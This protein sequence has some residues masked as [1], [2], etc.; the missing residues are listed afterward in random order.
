M[1]KTYNNNASEESGSLQYSSPEEAWH[2]GLPSTPM[3]EFLYARSGTD[4]FSM[5]GVTF[6]IDAKTQ[7]P[8]KPEIQVISNIFRG[9]YPI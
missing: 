4:L 9:S 1:H 6:P 7:L 5:E 2:I 3:D 8:Y